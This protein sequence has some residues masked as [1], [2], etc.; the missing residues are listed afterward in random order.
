MFAENNLALIE[1]PVVS[2]RRA[3][4]F[5]LIELLVVI[6]IIALLVSI[7]LPSLSRARQLARKVN[8]FSRVRGQVQAVHLYAS[9]NAGLLICGSDNPLRYPGVGPQPPVNTLASFQ[10]WLGINQEYSS[11]AGLLE[12]DYF[13]HEMLFCPSDRDANIQTEYEKLR[14]RSGEDAWGSYLYRQLDGQSSDPPQRTLAGLDTNGQGRRI[15]ALVF[16]MQCTMS[17]QGLP[18]KYNHDGKDLSMGLVDGS[19]RRVKNENDQLTLNGLTGQTYARLDEML[20]HA[21]SLSQ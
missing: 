1:S 11:H 19:A 3:D 17:W 4:G 9:E 20:E 6:A 7:L 15:R 5:T 14:T 12:G 10:I 16:D 2:K 13:S 18:T 8:C 21:D